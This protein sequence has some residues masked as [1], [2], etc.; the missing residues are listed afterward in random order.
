MSYNANQGW[1]HHWTSIKKVLVCV[2]IYIYVEMGLSYTWCNS[3]EL[4]I[5]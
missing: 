1:S 5:F 2:Y 4:H 3:K